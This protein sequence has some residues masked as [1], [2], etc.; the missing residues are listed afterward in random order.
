MSDPCPSLK[1]EESGGVARVTLARP[2]ALNAL[3]VLVTFL[4]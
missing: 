3:V 4:L 2:D 1:I